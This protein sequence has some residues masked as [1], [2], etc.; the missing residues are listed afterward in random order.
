[1]GRQQLAALVRAGA[2]DILGGSRRG[3]LWEAGTLARPRPAGE[4]ARQEPLPV[5]AAPAPPLPPETRFERTLTDYETMGLSVG[6]HLVAL[7]RSGLPPDTLPGAE[8]RETTDG[9]RVRTAGLVVARQ[10]PATAHG[11]VFLLL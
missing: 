9:S 8:L 7:V 10:R 5:P 11:I 6:W 3:M 4:D 2:C 1:L